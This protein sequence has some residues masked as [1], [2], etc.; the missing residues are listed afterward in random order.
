MGESLQSRR[1]WVPALLAA[2]LVLASG[3]DLHRMTAS[4]SVAHETTISI[5]ARHAQ[6]AAHLEAVTAEEAIGHCS[7]CLKRHPKSAVPLRDRV[8]G[9][10]PV[11]ALASSAADLDVPAAGFDHAPSRAPPAR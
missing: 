10:P 5:G 9:R 6:D 2:G 3:L 11:R 4:H 7:A 8:S 1:S